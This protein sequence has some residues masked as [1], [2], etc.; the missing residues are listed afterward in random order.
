MASRSVCIGIDGLSLD[1]G[2][3]GLG[4]AIKGRCGEEAVALPGGSGHCSFGVI[5]GPIIVGGS[6]VLREPPAGMRK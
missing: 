2:L 6:G 5:A 3:G 4:G 1:A